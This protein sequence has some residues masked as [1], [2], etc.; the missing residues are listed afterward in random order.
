MRENALLPDSDRMRRRLGALYG[1]FHDRSSFGNALKAELGIA[2]SLTYESYH[3]PPLI[4]KLELRD[5]LDSV[6]IRWRT[7]TDSYEDRRTRARNVFL[8]QVRRVFAEEQVRYRIDELGGVHFAVDTDFENARI[9]AIARL[10][11]SRYAGV[12]TSYEEAFATLDRVPPDGKAAIRAAFFAVENL[13]R[14]IF[15][16][17][18]QLSGAEVVKH[19]K[20][21]VDD[22]FANQKPAINLAQKQVA[23]FCDWIDGA[24]FY[25]H[26]PGTEEPAQPPLDLAIYMVA[27]AGAHLRWL[28]TFDQQ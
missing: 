27:Q 5:V 7:I 17:A 3:W 20:P 6:T 13:F 9:A 10:G 28:A 21:A 8:V 2:L 22:E 4:A 25:R 24:H 14:L 11:K 19:L 26:E 18:H 15:P 23:A 16:K 1:Q 12:R